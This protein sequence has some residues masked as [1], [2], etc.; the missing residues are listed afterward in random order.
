MKKRTFLFLLL[1]LSISTAQA[2]RYKTAKEINT[3]LKEVNSKNSDITKLHSLGRSSGGEEIIILEIGIETEHKQKDPNFNGVYSDNPG[4]FIMGNTTGAYA[5]GSNTSVE[6]INNIIEEKAYLDRN[7][8]IMPTLN[9]DA[10]NKINNSPLNKIVHSDTSTNE[11]NDLEVDE[12]DCE[13]IDGDGIISTMLV[14]DMDGEFYINSSGIV[15]KYSTSMGDVVRYSKYSE[16]I[17]NDKDGLY[18]EDPIGGVE[19]DRNFP[20][21]YRYFDKRSGSWPGS[22]QAAFEVM[23]FITTRRDIA[24]VITFGESNWCRTEPDVSKKPKPAFKLT[25]GAINHLPKDL[26][27]IKAINKL[28]NE[29]IGESNYTTP[30]EEQDGSFALWSYFQG[31]VH[32]YTIS[33]SDIESENKKDRNTAIK[34]AQKEVV[35]TDWKEFDHPTLGK[36]KLGGLKPNIWGAP[37]T[38][39]SEMV[40]KKLQFITD[41]LTQQLPRLKIAKYDVTENGGGVYTVKVWIKNNKLLPSPSYMSVKNRVVQP[42]IVTLE[43]A[44]TIDKRSS[45]AIDQV[46]G[47]SAKEITFN[48]LKDSNNITISLDSRT[49]GRDKI[50]IKL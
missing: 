26:V 41:D 11:D 33:L 7:W 30:Q 18:N 2:I 20:H 38:I 42:I 19:T 15:A 47:H 14:E 45:I 27:S 28:Y 8:F 46:E 35:Y 32:A 44:T 25:G 40:E 31:G 13:D 49:G 48:I 10:L 22:E 12:D 9:H 17:D 1:A 23:K 21:E 37:S 36:V 24:M 4:I 34:L 43:G 39:N 16:G 50:S 6:L 5:I 3:L 29:K